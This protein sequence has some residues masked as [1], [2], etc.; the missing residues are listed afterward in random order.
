MSEKKKGLSAREYLKQLE[1]LDMQ[2]NEDL[3]ELSDLK[4]SAMSTGGIDYSRERVQTSAVGD[5]L[6]SDVAR[7]TDFDEHIN[8]EIDQFVD[9]KKQIIKEIRGLRDK[10]MIQILTK[11]YVQ[12]KTVKVASQEMRKSYNHV[13]NL[14]SKALKEFEKKHP[15][16]HYLT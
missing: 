15:N 4:D 13:V 14:H 7:Y 1:V 2:I 11:V 6:C 10:N 9:A 5:R 12:F 8:E 16:L 3:I